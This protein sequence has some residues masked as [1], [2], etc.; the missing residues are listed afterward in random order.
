MLLYRQLKGKGAVE[1]EPFVPLLACTVV[2]RPEL[3]S[4]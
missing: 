1:L 4:L 2:D 3:T